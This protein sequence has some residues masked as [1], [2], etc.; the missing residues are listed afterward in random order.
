MSITWGQNSIDGEK[1]N[2]LWPVFVLSLQRLKGELSME[3][4]QSVQADAFYQKGTVCSIEERYGDFYSRFDWWQVTVSLEGWGSWDSHGGR[5]VSAIENFLNWLESSIAFCN[6]VN[7][8][9]G[10]GFSQSRSFMR[11]DTEICRVLWGGAN[12]DPNIKASG[13]YSR[14][15]HDLIKSRFKLGKISRV[16]SAFDSMTGTHEFRRV[17]SWL[18]ERAKDASLKVK[19]I[20][21]KDPNDGDTLYI[22]SKSSR[23]QIRLY[24]K[25]KEQRLTGEKRDLWWRAEIQYRPDSSHKEQTYN[26]SA[27]MVWSASRV[28]SELW[29]F[30]G[31]EK[32]AAKKEDIPRKAKTL[33]DK[34]V[35]FLKQYHNFIREIASI[36][37]SSSAFECYLERIAAEVGLPRLFPPEQGER[38]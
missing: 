2:K 10:N 23:V 37:G 9:G 3:M 19:W 33:D 25:G 22:G 34:T 1:T 35:T 29:H 17:A 28:A 11:G 14:F 21:N 38:G 15:I 32:L 6:P 26:W 5:E 4:S 13:H 12:E 8:R 24:E 16:D 31:G 30:L 36:E 7:G 20:I 27:G 18:E